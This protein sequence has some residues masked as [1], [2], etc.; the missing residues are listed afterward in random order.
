MHSSIIIRLDEDTAA[1]LDAAACHM[2]QSKSDIVCNLIQKEFS[3]KVNG[4]EAMSDCVGVLTDAPADLST[5][6]KYLRSLIS[7]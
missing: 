2:R 1:L 5:N 4:L 6:K 3:H 7:R